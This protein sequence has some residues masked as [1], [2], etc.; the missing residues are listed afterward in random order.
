MNQNDFLRLQHLLR[1]AGFAIVE[2]T[3]SREAFGS[4]HIDVKSTPRRRVIWD[5]KDGWLI[6]Q[7][8]TEERFGYDFVWNDVWVGRVPVDQT[9]EAAVEAVRRQTGAA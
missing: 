6:V 2:A 8:E 5:G 7:E 1:D 3:Y 4:W 9:C